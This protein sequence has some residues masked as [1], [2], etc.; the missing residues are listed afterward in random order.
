VSDPPKRRGRPPIDPEDASVQ[1]GVTLP[2]REFDRLCRSALAHE[3]SVP[4]LIRRRL[5][6]HPR[7]VVKVKK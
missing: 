7:P 6:S 3:V 2:A 5:Y 4:E 1:V